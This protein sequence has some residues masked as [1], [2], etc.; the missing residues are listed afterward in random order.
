MRIRNKS[1]VRDHGRISYKTNKSIL[2]IDGLFD[3]FE[4]IIIRYA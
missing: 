2:D 3:H 4:R 1:P